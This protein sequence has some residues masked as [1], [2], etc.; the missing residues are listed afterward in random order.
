MLLEL[1]GELLLPREHLAV[2]LGERSIL[3]G[4]V[5]ALRLKRGLRPDGGLRGVVQRGHL[6]GLGLDRRLERRARLRE[7][8]VL[9]LQ[10]E[11][12]G[13]EQLGVLR[14]LHRKRFGLGKRCLRRLQLPGHPGELGV[15][16]RALRGERLVA[17]HD[18]LGG[19]RQ[20][21]VELVRAIRQ[22]HHLRLEPQQL[23]R[24][25]DVGA[26]LG[27]GA[28]ESRLDRGLLVL[29]QELVLQ[30]RLRRG[31]H[32][33]V[34]GELARAGRRRRRGAQG[35]R[36]GQRVQRRGRGRVLRLE[37]RRH[38][39]HLRGWLHVRVQRGQPLGHRVHRRVQGAGVAAA[40]AGAAGAA[41]ALKKGAQTKL[42]TLRD[43]RLGW[44][45]R[46][47]RRAHS[48][49]T[50]DPAKLSSSHLHGSSISSTMYRPSS[51]PLVPTAIPAIGESSP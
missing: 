9:L 25:V 2:L 37:G 28:G 32:Q 40:A 48:S 14:R 23:V 42:G 5:V 51:S 15:E 33:P 6:L 13:V 19:G 24:I 4:Q 38:H 16:L 45:Q 35:A 21:G 31:R 1:L 7:L 41:A 22:R 36:G 49:N 27:G 30:L 50:H 17:A 34:E 3:A 44:P 39:H 29:L 46:H 10:L 20:V 12:L 11:D 18:A 26:R 43:Q 47:E 8:V